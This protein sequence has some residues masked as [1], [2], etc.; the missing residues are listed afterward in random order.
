[1]IGDCYHQHLFRD[2]RIPH[3]SYPEADATPGYLIYLKPSFPPTMAMDVRAY[4][5]LH[6]TFPHESTVDQ[7][8]TESQ[9]ESYRQLGEL[10]ASRLGP[11]K[12][13]TIVQFFD[14]T[15]EQITHHRGRPDADPA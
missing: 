11:E 13:A 1:M 5:N 3:I 6:E 14:A 2:L 15:R 9:F 10:E 8:F 4:G 12:P 7:F